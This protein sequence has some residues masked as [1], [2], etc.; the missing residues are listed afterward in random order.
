MRTADPKDPLP[1]HWKFADVTKEA[2]VADP[3]YSFATWFFDYDNDGWLI[4]SCLATPSSVETFLTLRWANPRA[5]LPRLYHNNHDGTFT[6]VSAAMQ[7]DRVI[8][9]MGA[10][11]GDSI[12][13]A[14]SISISVP[15]TLYGSLLAQSHVPQ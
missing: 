5:E 14:G 8:E 11:F 2:G 10:S 4:S 15:V 1:D 12:T 13:T 7:L 6:G 3:Y 9:P